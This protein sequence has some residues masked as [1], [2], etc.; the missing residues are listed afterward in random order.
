MEQELQIELNGVVYR[1]FRSFET[2]ENGQ[3]MQTIY[4][5]GKLKVD[6]KAYGP[7]D[8]ERMDTIARV[9]LGELIRESEQG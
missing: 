5:K 7:N 3:V 1:G 8:T 9:I 6:S 4:F 2:I